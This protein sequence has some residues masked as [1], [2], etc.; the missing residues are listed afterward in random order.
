MNKDDLSRT[1]DDYGPPSDVP[2]AVRELALRLARER[3][4]VVRNVAQRRGVTPAE[5]FR[6][7]ACTSSTGETE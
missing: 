3:M 6:D 5:V 7:A 2:G 1:I 4:Q